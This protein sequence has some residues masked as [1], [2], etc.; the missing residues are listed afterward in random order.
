MSDKRSRARMET[1]E[2]RAVGRASREAGSPEKG[3]TAGRSL[4]IFKSLVL[5]IL[6]VV[7]LYGMLNRGLFG[8]ELWLPVAVAILGLVFIVTLVVEGY[9]ADVPRVAWMLVSLLAILLAV[10]GLSLTW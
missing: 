1:G 4:T 10:K 2:M 6:M 8:V 7:T 5:V 9:V 3:Q